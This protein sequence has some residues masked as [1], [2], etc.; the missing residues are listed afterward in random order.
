LALV[1]NT[2]FGL[3][4]ISG[5]AHRG[6]VNNLLQASKLT[7]V[8]TAYATIGGTHLHRATGERI[9]RTIESLLGMGIQKLGVSHC[10]G[11]EASS[12]LAMAFEDR[13][14]LNNAGTQ[15]DLP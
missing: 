7:G 14:F 12:R 9:D 8:D 4:V 11:F 6:I 10:T 2:D 1:I 15:I 13:F 5:C 3:V